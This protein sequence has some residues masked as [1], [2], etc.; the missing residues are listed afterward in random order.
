[1]GRWGS[2]L[3][4]E[5]NVNAPTP[6][7]IALISK[8]VCRPARELKRK[9]QQK[10]RNKNWSYLH[11][12]ILGLTDPDTSGGKTNTKKFSFLKSQWTESSGVA[13]QKTMASSDSLRI[14]NTLNQRFS[15]V[16]TSDTSENT[17]HLGPSMHPTMPHIQVS[18][19][20]VLKLLESLQPYKAAGPDEAHAR[21]L[22]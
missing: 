18:V 5:E 10:I 22:K 9:I 6:N 21:V 16:F 20:G 3:P 19:E 11:G 1:M 8:W 2:P 13:P 7:T 17:P 14:A 15:S 12:A 4:H